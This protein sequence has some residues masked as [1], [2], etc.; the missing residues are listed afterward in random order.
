MTDQ[1]SLD[2]ISIISTV[3]AVLCVACAIWSL[4]LG[5]ELRGMRSDVSSKQAAIA[6]GQTLAQANQK[7]IELLAKAA[8]QTSNQGI[9]NLLQ[10]NGITFQ[11]NRKTSPESTEEG[12]Q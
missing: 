2:W 5:F 9:A 3:I 7:L 4:A 1:K 10:R 12:Q 11:V 6:R 8:A